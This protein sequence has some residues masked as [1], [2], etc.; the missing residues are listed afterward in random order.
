MRTTVII[1]RRTGDAGRIVRI[2]LIVFV[3]ALLSTVSPVHAL[4]T[5]AVRSG[6]DANT[7]AANDDGSTAA[8]S[9]G[10]TAKFFGVSHT[11]LFVNNNGSVT[12]VSALAAYSELD[13]GNTTKAIIAPFFTDIDTRFAGSPVTYGTGTVGGRSAF[14]ANWPGVDC[15]GG[16][17]AVRNHFQVLLI[18]RS[19]IAAGDFDIEFNY[20]RIGWGSFL[21]TAN[22]LGGE[23]V[24]RAGYADG[25]GTFFEIAGSGGVDAFIDGNSTTGLV[26]DKL[27]SSQLGRYVF[28]VR[29]GTPSSSPPPPPPVPSVS[30]WGLLIMGGAIIVVF[31]AMLRRRGPP[32]K[33]RA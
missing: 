14:G 28:P 20:D 4:G 21:S 23:H 9:L 13:L 15:F 16:G 27:N 22:C 32:F 25:A 19:D 18:D 1:S 24:V 5:N 7:L 3:L 29:S 26:N 6:F 11:E 2:A 8:V 31:V 30:T 17:A 12:F 33:T 10:F